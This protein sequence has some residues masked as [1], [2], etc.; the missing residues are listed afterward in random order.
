MDINA[1]PVFV[2]FALLK[3][4]KVAERMFRQQDY[5]CELKT[6]MRYQGDPVLSR[7][8]LKM[9]TVAEDRSQLQLTSD[10]WQMLQSSDVNHGASLEG[11]ELWYQGAYAWSHVCMAQWIRSVHSAA[12]HKETLFLISARDYIANVANRDLRAVR[13]ALLHVPNMNSTGRLP[14]V[15]LLHRQMKVR[16]TVTIC[17]TQAPV[18]SQGVIEHIELDPVDRLRWERNKRQPLCVL[19]M[20]PT[21]LVKIEDSE[22]DSG[23]GPGIV[24]VEAKLSDPFRITVEIP[25]GGAAEH[26]VMKSL[27]VRARR[28]QLPTTIVTASTLY[29]LQ[30]TTTI[31]GLIYHFKVP[32]RLSAAMKWIATYMALSRVRCLKE[33]RSIGLS[34]EIRDIINGGPPEGP[35]TNFLSMFEGK[36]EETERHIQAVLRELQWS[37]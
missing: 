9:R 7:I 2:V 26:P 8:L 14:A 37:E 13:D 33:F 4:H 24:A 6:T 18:D 22:I 35:L 20:H 3:E 23:L 5:V 30:G 12:H 1:V 25:A 28:K 16:L 17:P 15:G 27:D 32:R 31:P 34:E 11:T 10:E 36:A 19:L 29:S 21:L